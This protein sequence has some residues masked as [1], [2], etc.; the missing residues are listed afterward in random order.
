MPGSYE[1]EKFL[2]KVDLI[3][4]PI[5]VRVESMVRIMGTD[6]DSAKA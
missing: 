4:G 1:E 6:F 3:K 2:S 5:M